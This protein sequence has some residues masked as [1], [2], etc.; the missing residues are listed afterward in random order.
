MKIDSPLL[1]STRRRA[2]VAFTA[3]LSVIFLLLI[4]GIYTGPDI[5]QKERSSTSQN[6]NLSITLRK[7]LDNAEKELQGQN[8]TS[9]DIGVEPNRI[10]SDRC[11]KS[12]II[13]SQ[14]PT[15]PLP[16]GIPTYTVEI[17]NVCVS[18]CDISAIHLRCGWF[19][20]A[21]LVNP[22]VFKRLDFDN[23]LV[24][25]GKPLTNGRTLSFQYANT[26]PY[27]MTVSSVRC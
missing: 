22:R 13:V 17:M 5:S 10:W 21:R 25:N 16:N 4:I 11:S 24:N 1:S 15:E 19:S 12:D 9:E 14:G 7:L 2:A 23:C 18:G 8:E 3:G 6:R 26:F 27:S 20:S